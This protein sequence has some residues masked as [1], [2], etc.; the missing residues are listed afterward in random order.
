MKVIPLIFHLMIFIGGNLHAQLS[1]DLAK[2]PLPKQE[3][4]VKKNSSKLFFLVTESFPLEEKGKKFL[5]ENFIKST[6]IDFENEEFEV[7]MRYRFADDEMQIMHEEKIK[8]LF[9]QKVKKLIF[10]KNDAEQTFIPIE[11][12]DKKTT[13]LGY[14]ELLTEGKM[15]LLKQFQKDGKGNL[16]TELFFQTE[17]NPAECFKL[18]K[19]SVLKIMK[20]RKSEVSKFIV[21]NKLNVKKEDDLKK[22]FEYYNSLFL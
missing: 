16:D 20:N 2:M 11:Y 12:S 21:E 18:K 5:S 8:A 7:E 4:K 10:K 19:S 13:N 6:I 22:V 9:P 15:K 14:F 17:E 1:N 3:K